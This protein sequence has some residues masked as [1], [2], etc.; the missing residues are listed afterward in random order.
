MR[1]TRDQF[2]TT[3]RVNGCLHIWCEGWSTRPSAKH[4]SDIAT[5]RTCADRVG[6][7]QEGHMSTAG[8]DER[9][10]RLDH[11]V[12]R[13]SLRWKWPT[14]SDLMHPQAQ[15]LLKSRSSTLEELRQSRT[16]EDDT[17]VCSLC[18]DICVALLGTHSH[19]TI[20]QLRCIRR[21]VKRKR[22]TCGK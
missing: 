8:R 16:R 4:E 18:D 15:H 19:N 2:M 11:S 3:R 5:V 7:R 9:G 10:S 14:E 21:V 13:G 1:W 6:S 20:S 12:R 22:N 17:P